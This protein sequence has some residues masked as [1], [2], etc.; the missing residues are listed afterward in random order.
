MASLSGRRI[1]PHPVPLYPAPPKEPSQCLLFG[2]NAFLVEVYR[3][4]SLAALSVVTQPVGRW[5]CAPA[6]ILVRWFGKVE[7]AHPLAPPDHR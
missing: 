7:A 3:A 2:T 1:Y 6:R 4:D 5:Y